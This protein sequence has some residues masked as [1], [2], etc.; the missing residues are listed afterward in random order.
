MNI[1][2]LELTSKYLNP[3]DCIRLLKL[4]KFYRKYIRMDPKF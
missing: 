4:N 1:L 2:I 3:F